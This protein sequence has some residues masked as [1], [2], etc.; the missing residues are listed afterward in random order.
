MKSY[1]ELSDKV[2]QAAKAAEKE[3][4]AA[5]ARIDSICE[6]NTQKVLKAFTQNRVSSTHFAGTTGYGY[7]DAGRDNLDRVAADI[8]GC[9]DALVRHNFVSGTHALSVMLFGILRPGDTLLSVTGKPYDTLEEVIGISGETGEGSLRD[10]GVNFRSVPLTSDKKIDVDAALK[11]IDDSTKIVYIQR[12]GGY[13]TRAALLCEDI[14]NAAKAVKAKKPDVV[15]AVDNCYG[16][17]TQ[18]D[19]PVAVGADVMAGSLI[20]NIGGGLCRTGG[21]IAGRADLVRLCANRLTVVGQGKEIGCTLGQLSLMYQGL[22]TAPEVTAAAMKTAS[23]ASA[24]LSKLGFKTFPRYDDERGDIITVIEA[25]SRERLIAFVQGIQE[26]SPV[27][28]YAAPEPWAMPGYSDEVIMAAGAFTQGSSVEISCDGPIREPFACYLQGG[29][30]YYSGK[31]T[32]MCAAD[33]M[34]TKE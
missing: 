25:G 10:F 6:H 26:A 11:A 16:E 24:F 18:T 14:K 21:Y 30:T 17:F 15:V 13:D 32:V 28:S 1:D 34:L 2:K 29:L 23:F 3:C 27:D 19:E 12:S 5:F 31:M 8:F 7:D 33:K 20:K 9:E 22:F 4:E